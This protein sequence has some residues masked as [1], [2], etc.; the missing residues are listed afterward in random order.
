MGKRKEERM[1]KRERV[2]EQES[3]MELEKER[4]TGG[5]TQ[6]LPNSF[7]PEFL[8]K[9]KLYRRKLRATEG[10]SSHCLQMPPAKLQPFPSPNG[11][12]LSPTKE[13]PHTCLPQTHFLCQE[14]RQGQGLRGGGIG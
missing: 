10:Q 11:R 12:S 14:E 8:S 1:R 6:K 5:E 9:V 4:E 7:E 13:L 2:S 3:A